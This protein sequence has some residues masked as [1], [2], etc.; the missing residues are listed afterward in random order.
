MAAV[1]L[2]EG[3]GERDRIEILH[4][5]LVGLIEE[6]GI[7]ARDPIEF[8]AVVALAHEA[9]G[10]IRILDTAYGSREEAHVIERIGIH[11]RDVERVSAAHREAG[12]GTRLLLAD[13]AIVILDVCH[14]VAE[15]ILERL[16]R[17]VELHSRG[18]HACGRLSGRRLLPCVAVCHDDNHRAAL[19][20]R[21]KVI[22]NLRGTAQ[23]H[24]RLLVTASTVQKVEYGILL[25][26]LLVTCRRVDRHT[27]ALAE[28][29][30]VVPAALDAAVGNVVHTVEVAAVT[31]DDEYVGHRRNVTVDV[32]ICR[33]AHLHP[34]DNKVIAVEF[35]LQGRRRE[36]PYAILSAHHLARAYGLAVG[37]GIVT[38]HHY[39]LRL[40]SRK[41]ERYAVVIVDLRRH[42]LRGAPQSL[43]SRD[44]AHTQHG[45][46]K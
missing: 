11:A 38:H 19:A 7:S 12:H 8:Q 33:I 20:L 15:R 17:A 39:R 14:H 26:A 45:S 35:R 37:S 1:A 34:V 28:R 3:V 36:L 13:D 2:A 46:Q 10:H 22:Q 31:V 32:Y 21:D 43:L 24:P 44:C 18:R 6:V 4:V 16:L 30:A 25:L 42:H 29:R 27:A 9:L 41:A 23:R 40:G 5:V